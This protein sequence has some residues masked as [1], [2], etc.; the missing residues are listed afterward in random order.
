MVTLEIEFDDY[1]QEVSWVLSGPCGVV[2]E[3]ETGEYKRQVYR[4]RREVV[5]IELPVGV[6]YTFT[7]ADSYDDGFCCPRGSAILST[8]D[9]VFLKVTGDYG[10]SE[11]A[12]VTLPGELASAF[13]CPPS[14]APTKSI[15]GSPSFSPAPSL[16]SKPTSAPTGTRDLFHSFEVDGLCIEIPNFEIRNG[17]SLMLADC[18]YGLNQLWNLVDGHIISAV[19]KSMCIDSED[20]DV[21]SRMQLFECMHGYAPQNFTLNQDPH[22][23]VLLNDRSSV[24][25]CAYANQTSLEIV[26][27]QCNENRPTSWDRRYGEQPANGGPTAAPS[28]F[29]EGSV[30]FEANGLCATVGAFLFDPFAS[31]EARP[32]AT[33]RD[34]LWSVDRNGFVRSVANRN[35]CWTTGEGEYPLVLDYCHSSG[36]KFLFEDNGRIRL[37][38]N[39]TLCLTLL[40]VSDTEF[41]TNFRPIFCDD[42]S[43]IQV[44]RQIAWSEL[45]V[46]PTA[47]PSVSQ[48]PTTFGTLVL[49]LAIFFD[50]RPTEFGWILAGPCGVV[51]EA[52]PG[53]Y[54]NYVR[55]T[56]VVEFL[57]VQA[58]HS[59]NLT[60]LDLAGNGLCCPSGR[61]TLSLSNPDGTRDY[62]L[63]IADDFGASLS[64]DFTVAGT[65][66]TIDCAALNP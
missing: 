16:S 29:L 64:T 11:T 44:F 39:D 45:P 13:T 9:T 52:T 35:F 32:C 17:V 22:P 49:E 56:Q 37:A 28:T 12:Q 26:M 33:T 31:V 18:T 6:T 57:E 63:R 7:F 25:I 10:S 4:M 54:D 15:T 40:Q 20:V 30:V 23:N 34:F 1:P 5:Q 2:Q 62:F 41:E 55:R 48:A 61:V 8:D 50:F 38:A 43:P 46:P 51:A 3:V 27:D 24:K 66:T 42:E 53:H 47:A 36:D 59:Y 14:A 60:L 19:D 65:P 21:S 58:G